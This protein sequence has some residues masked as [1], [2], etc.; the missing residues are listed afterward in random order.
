MWRTIITSIKSNIPR[1]IALPNGIPLVRNNYPFRIT[2]WFT[3]LY[4]VISQGRI[5]VLIPTLQ[6]IPLAMIMGILAVIFFVVEYI[7]NR[8][9]W[10]LIREE[11]LLLG[12]LVVCIASLP[13]SL[14]PGN[15]FST[16]YK[17]YLPTVILAF[18]AG[19]ICKTPKD[20]EM[21]MWVYILNCTLIIYMSLSSGIGHYSTGVTDMYDV[22]D[23][24]M[25]L[26]CSLPIA[27][28][29][30][31]Q[32][33]GIKKS[34]LFLFMLL[35][36]ITIIKTGSRGGVLS[37][38]A[39]AGYLVLNARSKIKALIISTTV[40]VMLFALAPGESKER[41]ITMVR[42]ETEYDQSYGGRK[43]IWMRGITLAFRYPLFGCG[44]GNYVVA[45]GDLKE[46]GPWKTAHNSFLQIA[47]ELGLI[48]F[49]IYVLLTIGTFLRLRLMR[50]ALEMLEHPSPVTWFIKGAELSL[51]A[52]IVSTF[53]LSQA[54]NP[55]FYFIVAMIIATKKMIAQQSEIQQLSSEIF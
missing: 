41:F 21:I 5:H 15:S 52:F 6:K 45:D 4:F 33:K 12:L 1:H 38:T 35:A 39:I 54:Y 55:Q 18:I 43:H 42:P 28:Y 46:T 49:A 19:F 25:V 40:L 20:I 10:Y 37:L 31:L 23:I 26:I 53:F 11:K 32:Q 2:F 34:L 9:H 3:A 7:K 13:F 17:G 36:V 24:A 14:W 30:M 22:N 16:L 47:V 51:L 27:F 29:M 44:F 48:G 8:D 50:K